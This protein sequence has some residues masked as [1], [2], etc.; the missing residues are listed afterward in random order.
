MTCSCTDVAT[1]T[2]GRLSLSVVVVWGWRQQEYR[3]VLSF[4]VAC[5]NIVTWFVWLL[6]TSKTTGTDCV[7]LNSMWQYCVQY[8]TYV[9]ILCETGQYV[10]VLRTVRY[11]CVHTVWDWTVCGSTAYSTLHMCTHCIRLNSMWQYCVQYVTKL[12]LVFAAASWLKP[13]Q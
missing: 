13:H 4:V 10:A 8:V 7:R 6:N 1:V 2:I 3:L 12:C 5:C 11:I 9:Y